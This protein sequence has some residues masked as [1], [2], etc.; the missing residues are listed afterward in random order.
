MR[1]SRFA[2]CWFCSNTRGCV[3]FRFLVGVSGVLKV[4]G[5]FAH[6]EFVAFDCFSFHFL[7]ISRS[8]FSRPPIISPKQIPHSRAHIGGHWKSPLLL[9]KARSSPPTFG[10]IGVPLCPCCSALIYLHG[11]SFSY[12]MVRC[13]LLS[14]PSYAFE[15]SIMMS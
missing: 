7:N 14:M 1:R 6:S 5:R 12:R 11:A 3:F 2:T 13:I 10:L 4:G 15:S 8:S 9:L